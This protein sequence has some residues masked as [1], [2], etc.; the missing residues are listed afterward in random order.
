MPSFTLAVTVRAPH[1]TGHDT[2]AQAEERLDEGLEAGA[3]RSCEAPGELAFVEVG[4]AMGLTGD[5]DA[6][7]GTGASA[8]VADFDDD[9]DLDIALAFHG[10]AVKLF[11][12]S[13]EGFVEEVVDALPTPERLTTA[14]VDGDGDLDLLAGG[15]LGGPG[16]ALWAG[17][18]FEKSEAIE[19]PSIG[20]AQ[21]VELAPMDLD[22]DG[23]LDLYGVVNGAPGTGLRDV[24]WRGDGAG[25]F[26]LDEEAVPEALSD[27]HGFDALSLD[28]GS[29]RGVYV[30]NDFS[31]GN[32][33]LGWRGDSL[34]EQD[35]TC[36]CTPSVDGMGVD[37]GDMDRDGRP[38]LY[39]AASGRNVL[40]AAQDGGSFVD[41]TVAMDANP[42]AEDGSMA[43]SA[44]WLDLDND[45]WL[46]LAVA[47]GDLE[48][49]GQDLPVFDV[50]PDLLL[51]RDGAFV[52][53]GPELGLVE[54]GSFRS[55]VAADH[56]D[57][58]VLD[59][60][61]TRIDDPP[62]LYLSQ[63]CTAATWIQVHA[64]LH[65]RVEVQGV[66]GTWTAWVTGSAGAGAAP[67]RV[68]LGLG[69]ETEV[70]VRVVLPD[71]EVLEAEAVTVP[72]VLR[73]R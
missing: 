50:A 24:I 49:R 59:L 46:D 26:I 48:D 61:Y 56:N 32:S 40:L 34:A 66:D 16:L 14:D 18:G 69:E 37:V 44:S 64:P 1:E 45:G 67:H 15:Y 62:L 21:F 11:L 51:Q 52:D 19:S 13:P 70:D 9:G 53:V 3:L 10:H 57:D 20:A 71:G 30:V 29:G 36:T 47:Q 25:G 33:F 17:Q 4:E 22:R 7:H 42:L 54:Q 8:A 73:V 58:G 68:H 12:A 39:L 43:W 60:L 55:V 27:R 23:A 65:S 31:G 28:L 41:V 2:M 38:D 72:R 5:P 35:G 63:G 6:D